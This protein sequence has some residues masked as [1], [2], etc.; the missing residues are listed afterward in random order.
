MVD[1][2]DF[3]RSIADEL[4]PWKCSEKKALAE[5][6]ETIDDV[7]KDIQGQLWLSEVGSRRENR[8]YARELLASTTAVIK[9]LDAAS[10][11]LAPPR[12]DDRDRD[13]QWKAELTQLRQLL[14]KLAEHCKEVI[15]GR[16]GVVSNQD[17]GKTRAAFTV[18]MLMEDISTKK[19]TAG[20][21]NTAFCVITSMLIEAAT[22][23]PEANVRRACA[24]ALWNR[25]QV[26]RNF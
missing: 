24:R 14:A 5:I 3:I 8:Q 15:H 19:P 26:E 4:R 6:R 2:E 23:A 18:L 13:T 7:R 1:K 17:L 10:P 21:N 16:I 11:G 25:K 9:Q 22:G 20:D 12:W